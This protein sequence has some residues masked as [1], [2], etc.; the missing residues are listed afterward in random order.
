MVQHIGLFC[1][2]EGRYCNRCQQ[3]KCRRA[4]RKSTRSSDG[5]DHHCK[6]CQNAHQRA[7]REN[8]RIYSEQQDRSELAYRGRNMDQYVSDWS[9]QHVGL[10]CNCSG[11]YCNGCQQMKC[12]RA[13]GKDGRNPDGLRFQCKECVNEHTRQYRGGRRESMREYDK[14]RRL[15]NTEKMRERAHKYRET[16]EDEI[17]EHWNLWAKTHPE[18]MATH[19]HKY[20]ETHPEQVKIHSM[21]RRARKRQATGSY[22]AEE[23]R[24]LCACYNFTCLACGR[25]EPEIQLTPDHIVPLARGGTNSIDNIQP[26]CK[27]CNQS[28]NARTIDYR[29]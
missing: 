11:K 25:S 28:K 27:R 18:N 17:R 9:F 8:K 23:W 5:L 19:K 12:S 16:H 6:E 7:Y 1:N 15:K 22:T 21:Q 14:K 10:F 4:F 29:Q 20:K 26:L 2:C 13:F 24:N 3:V